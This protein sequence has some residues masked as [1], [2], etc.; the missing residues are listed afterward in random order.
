MKTLSI[1]LL[2][3]LFVVNASASGNPKV[4]TADVKESSVKWTGKKVAGEHYGRITL[5]SGTV[6]VAGGI[7]AGGT[8]VMDMNSIV[9][10]DLKDQAMNEKLKGHLK[11]D[12]FFG[13]ADY[14]VSRLEVTSVEKKAD[15]TLGVTGNLTI[16]G[17]T[18]PVSF[19]VTQEITSR[20]FRASGSMVINRA[21]YDIRYGSGSFFSNLGDRMIYD[22]FTLDFTVT[23]K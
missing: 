18:H 22:D 2:S 7:L 12:D 16:K 3:A 5:Q 15:G 17:I 1:I 4:Y 23:A 19:T 21:R 6:S 9:V 13:V 11:S 8:F 14:P 20:G 10:D